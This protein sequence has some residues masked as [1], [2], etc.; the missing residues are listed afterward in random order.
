MK[1]MFDKN[2]DL[3]LDDTNWEFNTKTAIKSIDITVRRV[4]HWLNLLKANMGYHSPEVNFFL[5]EVIIPQV[6]L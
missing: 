2:K 6:S 3:T 4:N 5:D 1:K